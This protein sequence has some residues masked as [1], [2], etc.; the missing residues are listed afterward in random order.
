MLR[1]T[2]LSAYIRRMTGIP[3]TVSE[4]PAQT[5]GAKPQGVWELWHF[6]N[7]DEILYASK[8][9]QALFHCL[10]LLCINCQRALMFT[11]ICKFSDILKSIT[12]HL[13]KYQHYYIFFQNKIA[14]RNGKMWVFQ[15]YL[16]IIPILSFR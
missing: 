14:E 9:C 3:L 11:F 13:N 2:P 8:Y 16:E 4:P 10:L 12:K 7:F 15:T 5:A 6:R 1:C